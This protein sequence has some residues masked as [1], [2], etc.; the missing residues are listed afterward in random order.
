VALER[1]DEAVAALVDVA[2]LD[3]VAE[4]RYRTL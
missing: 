1:H 3:P 2:A 4:I